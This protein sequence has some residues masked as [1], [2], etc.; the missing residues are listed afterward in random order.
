M[1]PHRNATR[2]GTVHVGAGFGRVAAVL[3]TPEREL[4]PEPSNAGAQFCYARNVAMHIR[5][6][7]HFC[8]EREACVTPDTSKCNDVIDADYA[9]RTCTSRCCEQDAGSVTVRLR[10]ACKEF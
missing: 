4:A 8:R 7:Y 1:K 3:S 5:F 6:V 10:V 2:H 9:T